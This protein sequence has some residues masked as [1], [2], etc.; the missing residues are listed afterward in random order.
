MTINTLHRLRV[1]LV[2]TKHGVT[3]PA[4]GDLWRNNV[5]GKHRGGR[6]GRPLFDGVAISAGELDQLWH[7]A[8]SVRS[9]FRLL[10]LFFDPGP[11]IPGRR[12]MIHIR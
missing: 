8:P 10:Q 1:V 6:W 9:R 7:R 5:E 4:V 3:H 12:F 11:T 2:V